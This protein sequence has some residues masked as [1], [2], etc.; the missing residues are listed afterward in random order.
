MKVVKKT[1]VK[2]NPNFFS[3]LHFD[4]LWKLPYE[5]KTKHVILSED[6]SMMEDYLAAAENISM[7]RSN[8]TQNTVFENCSIWYKVDIGTK[9]H[10]FLFTGESSLIVSYKPLSCFQCTH[11]EGIWESEYIGQRRA[12]FSGTVPHHFLE[13]SLQLCY[14]NVKVIT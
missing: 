12:I 9:S 7:A 5:V 11:S 2:P 6:F 10:P 3:K 1:I 8:V 4:S 13:N 14:G